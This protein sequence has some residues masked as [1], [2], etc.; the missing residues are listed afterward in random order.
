MQI[1]N[2]ASNWTHLSFY[3]PTYES[4]FGTHIFLLFALVCAKLLLRFFTISKLKNMRNIG[5]TSS[6][7][8]ATRFIQLN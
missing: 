1:D 3:S 4:H 7:T 2:R 5:L 6:I 8:F